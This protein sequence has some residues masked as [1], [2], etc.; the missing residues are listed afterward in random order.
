MLDLYSEHYA[1]KQ[2]KKYRDRDQNHFST[3]IKLA[4]KLVS[5]F[6]KNAPKI[7]QQTNSG[8]SLKILDLGC[9]IGTFALEF[10]KDGYQTMGLDFDATSLKIAEEVAQEDNLKIQWVQADATDFQLPEKVDVVIC[11]DLLEHLEDDMIHKMFSCIVKNLNPG[12]A[13]IFHTFPTEYDHIFYKNNYLAIP[14]LPFVFL[15]AKAFDGI[16]WLYD[17]FF[18]LAY[19]LKKGETYR[20][21]IRKTVHPNPLTEKRL[22]EMLRNHGFLIE[23]LELKLDEVNPLKPGQG[24]FAKKYLTRQPIVMRSIYGCA[25]IKRN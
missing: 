23:E 4:K 25:R 2:L 16:L 22:L 11:F 24:L 12:G 7:E 6:E 20:A 13:F 3:H 14:M 8:K 1:F 5:H 17:K 9:S 18:D 21:R 15:P 19:W 10:A